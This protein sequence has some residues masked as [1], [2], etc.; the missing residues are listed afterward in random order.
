MNGPDIDGDWYLAIVGFA[1]ATPW[2]HAILIT[3]TDLGLLLFAVLLAVAWWRARHA[4]PDAMA[5]VAWVPVSMVLGYLVSNVIK[6]VAAEPRPCRSITRLAT[7]AACPAPD[8]YAFPSNHA[9]I[10]AAAAVALW[11]AWRRIGVLAAVL[12]LLM[13]FSRVYV[14]VHYP[15]D[16]AA[17]FLIGVLAALTTP[18]AAGRLGRL[19]AR[20]RSVPGSRWAWWVG[21]GI[22]SPA[23]SAAP[24][25]VPR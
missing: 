4:R 6:V 16:V 24:E 13:G 23:D 10:A 1:R 12:A 15:H 7:L 21:P 11:L 25:R 3:Y 22:G 2:L 8:D 14:G 18:P 9:V 5:A 20:L 19:V 17:G